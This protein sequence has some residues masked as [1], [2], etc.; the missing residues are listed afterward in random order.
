MVGVIRGEKLDWDE[1][2]ICDPDFNQ[3]L[4]PETEYQVDKH[5]ELEESVL[6][7]D[8]SFSQSWGNTLQKA[9]ILK[10]SFCNLVDLG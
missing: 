9:A 4:I 6:I 3:L 7:Q 10:V 1:A 8:R 2:D 5:C